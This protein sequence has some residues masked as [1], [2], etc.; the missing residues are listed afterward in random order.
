MKAVMYAARHPF[1]SLVAGSALLAA[2]G[3]LQVAHA[4]QADVFVKNVTYSDLNL[5]S[6]QGARVLLSRLRL[7]SIEVCATLAS[8]DL[9][10]RAHWLACMDKAMSGAVAKINSTALTTLYMHTFRAPKG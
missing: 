6:E 1:F 4:D 2:S 8:S 3:M 10:L 7:A 9:T 5:E